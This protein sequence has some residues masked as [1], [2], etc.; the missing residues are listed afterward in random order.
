MFAIGLSLTSAIAAD[1]K[2]KMCQGFDIGRRGGVKMCQGF[3]IVH[4]GLNGH[5]ITYGPSTLG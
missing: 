4:L 1:S 5:V 3:D 2:V